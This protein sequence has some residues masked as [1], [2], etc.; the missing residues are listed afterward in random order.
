MVPALYA[1]GVDIKRLV[2]SMWTGNWQPMIG[3]HFSGH[4]ST[5]DDAV[6]VAH[7]GETVDSRRREREARERGEAPAPAE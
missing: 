5:G 4:E 1:V 2:K 7:D 3:S 6:D